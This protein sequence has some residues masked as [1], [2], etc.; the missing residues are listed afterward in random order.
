MKYNK[1]KGLKIPEQSSAKSS[2][3]HNHGCSLITTCLGLQ[4]AG[5]SMSVSKVY[6]SA[7]RHLDKGKHVKY[8]LSGCSK[9]INI[10]M[11]GAPAHFH[12]TYDAKTIR[13][14]L[15]AGKMILFEEDDPVH[16]VALV[17]KGRVTY[18]LSYGRATRV[19]VNKEIKR[20]CTSS[21]Y[22]GWVSVRKKK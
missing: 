17:R 11:P 2:Y 12:R 15:K 8:P 22:R 6:D 5:K 4:W 20:R 10:L 9:L 21:Y 16:S 7:K 14:A 1:W 19:T 18:R 13:K 3:I